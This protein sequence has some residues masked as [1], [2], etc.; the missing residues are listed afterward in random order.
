MD[1]DDVMLYVKQNPDCTSL[2]ISA[3]F[4]VTIAKAFTFMNQLIERGLVFKTTVKSPTNNKKIFSY[5]VIPAFDEISDNGDKSMKPA[6]I[7]KQVQ[8]VSNQRGVEVGLMFLR[9]HN[10]WR[11]ANGVPLISAREAG[12]NAQ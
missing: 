11:E 12:F 10:E 9:A 8:R 2:Q 4:D 1:Y 7:I 6:Q 5:R 3:R